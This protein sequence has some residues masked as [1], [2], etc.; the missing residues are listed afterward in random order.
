MVYTKTGCRQM[1]RT[2]A[3]VCALAESYKRSHWE[4]SS[5]ELRISSVT[6]RLKEF[7]TESTQGATSIYNAGADGRSCDWLPLEKSTLGGN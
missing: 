6:T 3:S 1:A 5:G 2:A 4:T 7:V